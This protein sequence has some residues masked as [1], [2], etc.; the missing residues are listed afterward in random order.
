MI[1]NIQQIQKEKFPTLRETMD[2]WNNVLRK[3]L[4]AL[5]QTLVL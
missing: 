5:K 2:H 3:K 4:S 1:E